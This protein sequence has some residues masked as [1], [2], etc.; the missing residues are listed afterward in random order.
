ARVVGDGGD[1]SFSPGEPAACPCHSPPP[2]V[3]PH[4][5]AKSAPEQLGEV[6]GMDT[7]DACHIRQPV[8]LHEMGVKILDA[9]VEALVSLEH[10]AGVGIPSGFA[11]S[12]DRLVH[13]ESARRI[14]LL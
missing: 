7:G 6:H 10:T 11:L 13:T 12:Y 3:L 4:G 1:G 9:S 2:Q 14:G 5:T 8:E